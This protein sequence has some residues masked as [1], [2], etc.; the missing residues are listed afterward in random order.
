MSMLFAGSLLM[1]AVLLVGLGGPLSRKL[2]SLCLFFFV[3]VVLMLG[4]ACGGGSS[5]TPTPGGN[6][7]TPAG[8]YTIVVT[9]SIN[10]IQQSSPAVSLT[11]Q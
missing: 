11:V 5:A 6:S 3:L 1:P 9:G 10:G 8:M 7:G 4:A 2:F